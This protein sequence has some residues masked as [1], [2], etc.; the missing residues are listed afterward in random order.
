MHRSQRRAFIQDA[1]RRSRQHHTTQREEHQMAGKI[2]VVVGGQYGSEAKG[3]VAGWLAELDTP[4]KSLSGYV[5]DHVGVRVAGP[6]AGHTVYG[7]D[8]RV[9]EEGE[10]GER[11]GFALRQIP[12][13]AV[14]NHAAL[15][16]IAAGS[17]VDPP[18]LFA[19]AEDLEAAGHPVW[20][21]LIIDAQATILTPEHHEREQAM[22]IHGKIG[23]TGKGIGA[24]RADRVMRTAP[25]AGDAEWHQEFK[26]RGAVVANTQPALIGAL[27][28]GG[29][30]V[31]E[32]T[33]GYGL[34]LHA[35]CY[36]QCTSS[37]TRAID[38]LA[39]AG[40]S[41]WAWYCDDF[42]VWVVLR[43]YPI[44]VAGNSGPLEGE[45]T[46]DALGLPEER[47]TVTHKVR[48]VGQWDNSLARSAVQ[49]N[50]GVPVVKIALTMADQ[51]YP[52]VA[53]LDAR[54]WGG[55]W[56]HIEGGG[57]EEVDLVSER[58]ETIANS[59][60]APVMYV[61]TGP[62]SRVTWEY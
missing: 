14:T 31:I 51:R 40:L 53:R 29:H 3:A 4:A 27:D 48:R 42:D 55:R 47:T 56:Q 50:G 13:A 39:M 22:D 33:Q 54:Y 59:V 2:S 16:V 37:D 60:G 24:A 36:P 32:G 18:V 44:R 17:E 26:Q 35:G 1:K 10:E 5:P 57:K 11:R 9:K 15:L 28:R 19:E 45:T 7:T 25:L 41:P 21:R 38:F 23:S 8:R 30:V 49:A 52:E 61:G 58:A 12:V 6:N 46:W 20:N 62:D 43:E 34:G